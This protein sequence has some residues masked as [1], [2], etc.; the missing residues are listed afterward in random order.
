MRPVPGQARTELGRDVVMVFAWNA[1]RPGDALAIHNDDTDPSAALQ[2]GVVSIVQTRRG[3]NEIAVQL[4]ASGTAK[5][6]IRPRRLAVHS[7]PLNPNEP[8]WRCDAIATRLVT[9][10]P[11]KG[12]A[13]AE[14]VTAEAV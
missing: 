5:T 4:A 8:C 13:D 9:N 3:S 10:P 11:A 6:V 2:F 7:M 12:T 1:L 14:Q